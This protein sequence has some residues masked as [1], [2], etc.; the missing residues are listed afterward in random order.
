MVQWFLKRE[1]T[2]KRCQEQWDLVLAEQLPGYEDPTSEF[3]VTS[4]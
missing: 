3:D 4:V 1:T 2:P